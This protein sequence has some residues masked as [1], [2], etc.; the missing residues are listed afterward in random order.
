MV[1]LD[2]SKMPLKA[3]TA[4]LK[5]PVQFNTQDMD[6]PVAPQKRVISPQKAQKK[7]PLAPLR[8]KFF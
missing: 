1:L 2:R 6:C 4:K 7:A 3:A 5:K 8:E